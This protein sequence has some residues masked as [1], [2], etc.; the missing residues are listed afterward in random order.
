MT[1]CKHK[2]GSDGK[3]MAASIEEEEEE[4]KWYAVPALCKYQKRYEY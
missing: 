2:L 1:N 3:K 4:M